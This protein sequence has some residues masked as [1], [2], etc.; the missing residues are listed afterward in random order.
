MQQ[1]DP[2]KIDFSVPE[3]YMQYMAVNKEI[4]FTIEGSNKVFKAK[5]YAIEAKIDQATRTIR[6]R[7]SCPNRNAELYPGS[8]A[9]IRINLMP[10]AKS[11][12]IPAGALIPI[13]G[14]Q[15][16]YV[17]KDGAARPVKVKTGVRTANDIEI[18][19]GLVEYDSLILSGLLQ[20]KPGMPVKGKLVK[21]D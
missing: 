17:I 15:Q 4:D 10:G 5:I 16:V 12:V 2:I 13:L 14:G 9:N 8:F 1:I 7:A 21:R 3:K 20:I 18:I 11:I 19:E 6:V